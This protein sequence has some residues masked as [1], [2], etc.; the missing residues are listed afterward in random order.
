MGATKNY[1]EKDGMT[2]ERFMNNCDQSV[3]NNQN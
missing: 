2:D 3:I 1:V